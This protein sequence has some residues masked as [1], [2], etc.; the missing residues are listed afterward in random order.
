MSFAAISITKDA[1]IFTIN[2]TSASSELHF[3]LPQFRP[4]GGSGPDNPVLQDQAFFRHRVTGLGVVS[5]YLML[6]W[7]QNW[8]VQSVPHNY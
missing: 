1:H 5:Q 6:M 4:V 7:Y 8:P 3:S 2:E